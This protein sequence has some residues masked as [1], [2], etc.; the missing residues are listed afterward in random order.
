MEQETQKK[1]FDAFDTTPIR[2]PQQYV[3]D[4]NDVAEKSY[5]QKNTVRV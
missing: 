2:V 1:Q 3:F 5:K 4:D